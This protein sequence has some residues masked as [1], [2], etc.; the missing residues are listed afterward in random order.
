MSNVTLNGRVDRILIAAYMM[1]HD[2][3]SSTSLNQPLRSGLTLI[4]ETHTDMQDVQDITNPLPSFTIPYNRLTAT[5][6]DWIG[7]CPISNLGFYFSLG[8]DQEGKVQTA[9]C[10]LTA[11]AHKGSRDLGLASRG[12]KR[13]DS[14]KLK[15]VTARAPDPRA[16]NRPITPFMP[17]IAPGLGALAVAVSDSRIRRGH[18]VAICN[19]LAQDLLYADSIVVQELLFDN[20]SGRCMAGK[21]ALIYASL[22]QR[23]RRKAGFEWLAVQVDNRDNQS[24]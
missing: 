14:P 19:T 10:H 13:E 1:D 18:H 8:P 6:T 22:T 4:L 3:L 11:V 21:K 23:W 12:R 24:R 16:N 17:V 9:K 5:V 15:A 2:G 20:D 7:P